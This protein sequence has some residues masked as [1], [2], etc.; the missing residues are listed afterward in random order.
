MMHNSEIM[1]RMMEWMPM[2]GPFMWL[3]MVLFWGG[4]IILFIFLVQCFFSK[5]KIGK[6]VNPSQSALDILKSR[7]AKGEITQ[8]EYNQI[9][10]DLE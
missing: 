9:K 6:E 7:Y 5:E 8:E 10:K 4:V 1:E 3:F 2:M